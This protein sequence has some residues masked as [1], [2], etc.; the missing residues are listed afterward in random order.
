VRWTR[1]AAA[2]GGPAPAPDQEEAGSRGGEPPSRRSRFGAIALLVGLFSGALFAGGAAVRWAT[3]SGALALL[4]QAGVLLSARPTI[5]LVKVK[6]DSMVLSLLVLFCAWVLAGVVGERPRRTAYPPGPGVLAGTILATRV[7]AAPML[8]MAFVAVRGVRARLVLALTAAVSFLAITVP[9]TESILRLFKFLRGIATHMGSYGQGE[10]GLMTAAAFTTRLGTLLGRLVR[11][12]QPFLV[13]M[14]ATAGVLTVGTVRRGLPARGSPSRAVY[15]LLWVV[16]ATQA[17]SVLAVTKSPVTPLRYLVPVFATLGLNVVAIGLLCKGW[18]EIERRPRI[19]L[20]VMML[21]GSATWFAVATARQA[22]ELTAQ[23]Q[24][25]L[26]RQAEETAIAREVGCRL[27][28][29][30]AA[31][32]PQRALVF[33]NGFSGRA[34][35]ETLGR[36]YPD[37]LLWNPNRRSFSTFTRAVRSADVVAQGPVCAFGVTA[38]GPWTEG[39]EVSRIAG[40]R[41]YLVRRRTD[42][43]AAGL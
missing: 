25:S 17:M 31:S 3:G 1:A 28:H 20:A 4:F 21:A 8:A 32:T 16:L 41:G 9:A 37:A 24:A 19:V 18:L 26:A 12:E 30:P 43:S 7:I 11:E 34:F 38:G 35:G 39:L 40:T 23:R 22:G 2:R 15:F 13:V 36:L 42:A 27:L 14:V 29:G 10:A 6:S 5:D 33:A